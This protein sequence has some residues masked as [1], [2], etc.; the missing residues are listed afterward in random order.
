MFTGGTIWVLTPPRF[1]PFPP[2]PPPP[3]PTTL[4]EG[5]AV[6]SEQTRY[7]AELSEDE[8]SDISEFDAKASVFPRENTRGNLGANFPLDVWTLA[9]CQLMGFPLNR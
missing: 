1:L 2:S 4:Q 3:P 6:E 7:S 5:S 8:T 9:F